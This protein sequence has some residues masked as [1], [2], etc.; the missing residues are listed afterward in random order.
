MP[1]MGPLMWLSLYVYF[2]FIYLYVSLVIYYL[3][4][5]K[6]GSLSSLKL[7]VMCWNM[8]W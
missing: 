1:Q 4:M 8:K 5:L 7:K 2:I 3:F 6:L